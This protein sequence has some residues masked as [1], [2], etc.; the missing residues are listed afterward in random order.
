MVELLD[1]LMNT[2]YEKST[3]SHNKKHSEII[4][5]IGF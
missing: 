1:K 5:K 2:L 4:E 3:I